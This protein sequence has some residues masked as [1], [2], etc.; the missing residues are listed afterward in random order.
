[1]GVGLLG[2]AFFVFKRVPAGLVEVCLSVFWLS[3]S[4]ENF[5]PDH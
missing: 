3:L 2:F 4:L 5:N 1:M